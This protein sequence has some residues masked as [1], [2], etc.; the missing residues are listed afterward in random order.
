MIVTGTVMLHLITNSHPAMVLTDK[1]LFW[2][3]AGRCSVKA[4]G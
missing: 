2:N 1:A 3:F 4:S